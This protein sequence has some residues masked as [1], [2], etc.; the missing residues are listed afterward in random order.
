[1]VNDVV[2]FSSTG[3]HVNV[4]FYYDDDSREDLRVSVVLSI[5]RQ[6]SIELREQDLK[7]MLEHCKSIRGDYE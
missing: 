7:N 2:L 1:M 5:P 3:R 4:N 6:C